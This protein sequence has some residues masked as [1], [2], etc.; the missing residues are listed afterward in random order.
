[1]KPVV[2]ATK[3]PMDSGKMSKMS[4]MSS[5]AKVRMADEKMTKAANSKV[6]RK[7]KKGY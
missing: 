5:A 6:S 2:K 4:N 3:N 7:V 1:M